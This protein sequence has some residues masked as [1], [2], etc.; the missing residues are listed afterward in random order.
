MKKIIK[1]ILIVLVSISFSCEGDSILVEKPLDFYTPD[2]SLQTGTQFQA[3]INFLYNKL[4][5]FNYGQTYN[6][7]AFFSLRYATDF[8][9]NATDY[10]PPV[11]LNDYR[12]TMVPTFNVP[13][14][15]W[16][17]LYQ[18][19]T[20]ANVV[21]DRAE[22][23]ESL[24]DAEKNNF[25]AQA[26]FFRAYAY[27]ILAN[28]YGGVPLVL[29]E[30]QEPRRDF[31]R[32]S[33]AE[34]YNQCK[35][36]LLN[37]IPLLG[38][39]DGVSDGA[40]SKQAA[41]HL[42]TEV[43]ISLESYDKAI[44]TATEVIQY[45]GLSL[46]TERFGR[47]ADEPGD[48]FRDLFELDN[49]NR[50]SGNTEGIL[51]L[52]R[53]YL[54]PATGDRFY[55][56]AW[57]LLPD[58]LNLTIGSES[59]ILGY[60]EKWSQ[61]G[62]GW[63]RPTDHFFNT[64]WEGGGDDIRNSEYNIIRDFR[65]D[66]VSP[67]SPA[68]G[69][70]YVAD[71]YA[72]Q[73]QGVNDRIRNWFPIIKKLTVSPGDFPEAFIKTDAEGNALES[74]FGGRLLENASEN[75]NKDIYL[76]RLAETY[77]L[78]AEAYVK[79]GEPGLA[80]S[81]INVLRNRAGAIPATAGDVDLDYILDERLRELYAEELRM[82]TLTRMGKQYDRTKRFNEKSGV[83]IEEYHNLWPIPFPEIERNIE[84]TIEQNPGY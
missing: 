4:R 70:F 74:P 18:I 9:V 12:N 83:S 57:S 53:D 69:K 71:G 36:D 59:A 45:S 31:V 82:V 6:L 19:V 39:V 60:N 48:V 29:E 68:Y 14:A 26:L 55:S 10:E 5:D 27:N 78:R 40:L 44:S 43:Y 65:I 34:V 35:E 21:I 77:L 13:N 7:D 79:N 1:N 2:N 51:V 49:Q 80:T 42:L 63:M 73:A 28:L 52:Q 25:Q 58:M 23:S 3:S 47:Y 66:G 75:L 56:N 84:A 17:Q 62:I 76:Y 22:V 54:N 64:I 16:Q 72:D 33:R 8:A 46:M 30:I 38:N 24:T 41:Q 20:N 15:I 32:A 61:R 81:D 37:A 11:K 67:T 50:S